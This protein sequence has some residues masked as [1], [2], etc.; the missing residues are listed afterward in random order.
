MAGR[1]MVEPT[2]T[3]RT[4]DRLSRVRLR[5]AY[6]GNARISRAKNSYLYV[7]L[8]LACVRDFRILGVQLDG[9]SLASGGAHS[10]FVLSGWSIFYRR[11]LSENGAA[12]Y[13]AHRV[14]VR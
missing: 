7:K 10:F 9:R 5:F 6:A 2:R 13:C 14:R 3:P 4:H 11:K 1:T 12:E 8:I